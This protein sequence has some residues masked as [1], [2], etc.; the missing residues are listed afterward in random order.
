MDAKNGHP[1][2]RELVARLAARIPAAYS[3]AGEAASEPTALASLALFEYDEIDRALDA[4]RWL[5]QLQSRAGSV[6]VTADRTAPCWPTALAMMVWHV[7]DIGKSEPMFRDNLN[8]AIDWALA[9]RGE[10]A[11]RKPHFDHDSTIVGW[12]WAANTHSWIEPTAMF[13]AALKLVGHGQHVRTRDGVRLLVDR[14][15]P[16]G[17]CNYGNTIVLG[18]ALLPHVQPTGLAM[19]ALANEAP[20]EERVM[21]SLAYLERETSP[22]LSASSLCFALLGLAA[23]GRQPEEKDAWLQVAYRRT[24]QAGASPYRLALIALASTNSRSLT[25]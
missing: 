7:L 1:W 21:R 18:Q 24:C 23:H 15:L 10:S 3:A 13:V 20:G 17:G 16:A 22:Q 2:R 4:A 8:R 19:L 9:E 25:P 6:G 12:S 14:Q 5:A 11:P